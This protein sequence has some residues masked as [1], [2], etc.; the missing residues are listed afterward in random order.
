MAPAGFGDRVEGL[1]AVAAAAAAGRV[2]RLWVDRG[3]LRRIEYQAVVEDVLAS[4]GTSSEMEDVISLAETTAPQG[5]VARCVPRKS[6][7]LNELATGPG[8]AAV[9]VLDHVVDPHNVGAIARSVAAAGLSGLVLASRRA[10]PLSAAAF[11]AAAGALETLPVSR[12]TSIADALSQLRRLGLWTVGLTQD[13]G[14]V[15]WG[16]PLLAEPV[17][18]VVGEE[19]T[20]LSRLVA[21]RTEV[22]VRI[23]ITSLVESLNASVAAALAAF[24]VLR[25][26]NS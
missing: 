12:V 14:Q 15:L 21:D 5:V 13:A 8:S 3:R 16:L 25:V 22:R 20:G 2:E 18:I 7:S 24:E 10:A 23:P 9:M 17:A 6:V 26:R 19:G 11:K 4:G 1:H